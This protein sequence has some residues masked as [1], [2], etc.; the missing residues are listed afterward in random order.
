MKAYKFLEHTADVKFQAFGK[1]IEEAFKNS[2]L[3]FQET[4]TQKT[5]IKPKIK[6]KLTIESKNR[7]T[8]RVL[9]DFLEEFLYLFDTEGFVLSKITDIKITK[10]NLVAEV[11]GDNYKNYKFTNDIK[12]VTYNDMFVKEEKDKWTCQVVLDV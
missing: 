5:K 4:L 9:L 2:A 1:T 6:K 8:E 7:G 10:N 11:I 12:A 3:A